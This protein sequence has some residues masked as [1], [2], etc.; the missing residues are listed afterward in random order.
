MN[1]EA[2]SQKWAG[3]DL[4]WLWQTDHVGLPLAAASFLRE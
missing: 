2:V 4:V 1:F 3:S